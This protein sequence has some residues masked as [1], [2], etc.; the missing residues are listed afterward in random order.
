MFEQLKEAKSFSE[1]PI[2]E[3]SWLARLKHKKATPAPT[4]WPNPQ[5]SVGTYCCNFGDQTF[6]EVKDPGRQQLAPLEVEVQQLLN[7]HN[8]QF[9]EREACNLSFSLFMVGQKDT[10]SCPTLV[11]ISANKQSRQ[12]VVDTIR[13]SKILEKY[14]GVSLGVSSKHPRH[15]HS[16]PAKYI[17][18]GE[19]DGLSNSFPSGVS[20]YTRKPGP[21]V[22]SGTSV[23]IPVDDFI[24]GEM[25]RF[26]RATLGGFLDLERKDGKFATVGITVA[27]AFQSIDWN[28]DA[29]DH[30]EV[31][32]DDTFEFEFDGPTPDSLFDD[33]SMDQ[34][35]PT[36][37]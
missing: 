9:K 4:K 21:Q 24:P 33:E 10:S 1:I 23:Y 27:H 37:E 25:G 2:T 20:V 11:I 22:T 34:P 28:L 8:E 35:S 18:F 16:G 32:D 5:Q 29:S 14:P 15:P 13:S 6:W 12:K 17:A 31:S 36:C 7:T 30:S 3:E 19:K 26:R